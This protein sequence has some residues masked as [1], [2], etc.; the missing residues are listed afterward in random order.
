MA[1]P[2]IQSAFPKRR[3]QFGE[4]SITLLTDIQS[5][6]PIDYLYIMAAMREGNTHP[7]VY[8][9]CEA[10]TPKENEEEKSTC[11]VRVLSSEQE[12][13]ISTDSQWR[14]EQSFCEFALE[15]IK[16]MFELSDEEPTPLA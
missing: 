7:E 14:N 1:T 9:T 11:R 6:D 3:Y 4:F 15:G 10:I 5:D 12:H 13:I 8:I 16:Q 2:H